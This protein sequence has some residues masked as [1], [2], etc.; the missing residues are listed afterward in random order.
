[1]TELAI[2][3]ERMVMLSPHRRYCKNGKTFKKISKILGSKSEEF[4]ELLDADV[5]R[6]SSRIRLTLCPT[7]VQPPHQVSMRPRLR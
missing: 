6:F 4:E 1:L 2:L 5:G 3:G 7:Y